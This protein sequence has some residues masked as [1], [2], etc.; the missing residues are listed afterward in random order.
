[1]PW[2]GSIGVPLLCMGP[3]IGK[4]RTVGTPVTTMDLAGTFI[5]YAGGKPVRQRT[6][7]C[8]PR[9][10]VINVAAADTHAHT[11]ACALTRHLA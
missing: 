5:D 10:V 8:V 9:V 4:G 3:G 1:M 2:S 11:H 6:C 7:V